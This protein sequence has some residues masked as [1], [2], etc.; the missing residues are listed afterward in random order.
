MSVLPRVNLETSIAVEHDSTL[1]SS[2]DSE[3]SC[4]EGCGDAVIIPLNVMYAMT[5]AIEKQE[6]DMSREQRAQKITQEREM[7]SRRQLLRERVELLRHRLASIREPFEEGQEEERRA[8]AVDISMEP[9]ISGSEIHAAHAI[10]QTAYLPWS[11]RLWH[12]LYNKVRYFVVAASFITGGN[13]YASEAPN[14]YYQ[15]ETYD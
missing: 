14:E 2:T 5:G 10:R 11:T 6:R 9:S 3:D 13:V 4:G 15:Q 1:L 8:N 7:L 12:S